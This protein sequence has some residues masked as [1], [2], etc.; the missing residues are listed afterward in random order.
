MKHLL[1]ILL[2]L[3]AL[4]ICAQDTGRIDGRIKDLLEV[5]TSFEA[6]TDVLAI[7]MPE[8]SPPFNELIEGDWQE[9]MNL[10]HGGS[11]EIPFGGIEGDVVVRS[12]GR[13]SVLA[14]G[15]FALKEVPLT[16]RVALAVL[17]QGLWW[18]LQNEIWLTAEASEATVEIPFWTTSDEAEQVTVSEHRLE[19]ASNLSPN[20]KYGALQL[21]ET[22]VFENANP[23]AAYFSGEDSDLIRIQIALPPKIT[24]MQLIDFYGPQWMYAAGEPVANPTPDT[25]TPDGSW[26]YGR[27]NAMHGTKGEWGS[28]AQ[29]SKDSWHPLNSAGA[30]KFAGAGD[31]IYQTDTAAGPRVAYLRFR[32]VVPPAR[33][34][35]PGKLV[36]RILHSTGIPYDRPESMFRLKRQFGFVVK[37]MQANLDANVRMSALLTGEH[38]GVYEAPAMGHGMTVMVSKPNT[39]AL[40]AGDVA[41]LV[42]GLSETGLEAVMR[43]E[44]PDETQAQNAPAPKL[45]GQFNLQVMFKFLAGVF[46]LAFLIVFVHGLSKPRE[47]QRAK[48]NE[49]PTNRDG[50]KSALNELKAE[51]D[52]GKLPATQYKQ[53]RQRLMDHLIELDGDDA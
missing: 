22:I 39:D 37:S 12:I 45:G 11:K 50:L 23:N 32:R 8:G 31:T 51:Y 24:S 2:A 20:L 26:M 33:D 9:A 17:V 30:L 1:L 40:A 3:L 53:H 27:A 10:L 44:N 13:T 29:Y 43:I 47:E 49:P 28:G 4:P 18:P 42:F 19:V 36:I 6:G 14:D 7:A 52:A 5:Q 48:L 38:R 16:Q 41:E 25:N 34:G 35:Q 15:S 21:R 46:G